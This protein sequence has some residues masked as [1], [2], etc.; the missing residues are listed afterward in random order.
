MLTDIN[1]GDADSLLTLQQCH[2]EQH[3]LLSLHRQEDRFH[4]DKRPL[5]DTH[6]LSTGKPGLHRGCAIVLIKLR[7]QVITDGQRLASK[8]DNSQYTAGRTQR[9]PALT[10]A[11]LD[12]QITREQRFANSPPAPL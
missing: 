4:I 10:R 7:D 9:R 3:S 6:P 12:K 2:Q 11:E 5:I 1:Q 8:T